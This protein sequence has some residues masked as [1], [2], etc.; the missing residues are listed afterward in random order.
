M[1]SDNLLEVGD[2]ILYHTIGYCAELVM[3][4]KIY[5]KT[6]RIEFPDGIYLRVDRKTDG[7]IAFGKGKQNPFAEM[8]VIPKNPR[9]RIR[10]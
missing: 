8:I 3:V 2:M 9:S 5:R 10:S 4:D 6:V 1:T 7:N